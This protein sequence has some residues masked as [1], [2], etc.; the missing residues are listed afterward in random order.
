MPGGEY[1]SVRVWAR[2]GPMK[3]RVFI[4][5]LQFERA[6]LEQLRVTVQAKA[7]WVSA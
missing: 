2:Y 3:V 5:N 1:G 4:D 7:N 6:T